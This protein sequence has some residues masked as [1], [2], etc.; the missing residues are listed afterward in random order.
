MRFGVITSAWWGPP[1]KFDIQEKDRRVSWLEL[2]YDLVYVIAI[3][4]ITHHLSAHL[5]WPGF[6]EY[7]SLFM[8][9][10]WGWLNGSLYYDLHGN[11]GL[12][13]RLMTLWQMMIVS[14][15][16]I[17]I[18]QGDEQRIRN[19]TVVLMIMQI[20]LTYLWWSVGFYDKEHRRYNLPY[21]ISYLL[22]LAL[23]GT[24]LAVPPDWMK[25]FIPLVIFLN[26]LPPFISNRLLRRDRLNLN[27]SESM[28][29]RMGL[30]TIIVFGE[31]V[32]GVVNGITALHVT[33]FSSWLNFGLAV[34]IVFSLWW[35][36]FTLISGRE[37]KKGF[38]NAIMLE[39]LFIPALLSLGVIASCFAGLFEPHDGVDSL[40]PVFCYAIFV[41][42]TGICLL[43]GLVNYNEAI[44][45]IKKPFRIS[46][47]I[48]AFVFLLMGIIFI[49][50]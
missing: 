49:L 36:F 6:L 22:S 28:F 18:D 17:A 34:A 4:R 48:S 5:S 38:F 29:E 46:L 26:Y 16:A 11:T 43:M 50:G 12:R 30:F 8:M 21:T 19:I 2:F 10:Y 24:S 23:M 15:L 44:Q 3:A 20:Y 40:H 35:I 31:L 39:I 45:K 41:F 14:A 33:D 32:L 13:T 25:M 27:M 9:I 47:L 42:L 37:V 1:K 7:I